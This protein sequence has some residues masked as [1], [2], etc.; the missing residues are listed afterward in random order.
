MK[1]F[2]ASTESHA[3]GSGIATPPP[4]FFEKKNGEIWCILGHILA[5]KTYLFFVK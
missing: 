1:Y 5:F 4:D 2:P 3:R